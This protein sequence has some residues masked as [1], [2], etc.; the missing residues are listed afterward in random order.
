MCIRDRQNLDYFVN[1]QKVSFK[2]V[3][4]LWGLEYRSSED[5]LDKLTDQVL[6]ELKV[7][8]S[9]SLSLWQDFNKVDF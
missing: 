4:N 2:D 6:I 1:E 3:A 7:D 9:K 5:G 8:N